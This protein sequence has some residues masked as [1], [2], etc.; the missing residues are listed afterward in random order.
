MHAV[1]WTMLTE[2]LVAVLGHAN[3]CHGRNCTPTFPQ[4]LTGPRPLD[5]AP[6]LGYT[7]GMK[8]AISLPDEVFE[9]AEQLASRLKVSRSELYAR[10]LQEYVCRH[11]PDAVTDAYDQICSELEPGADAFARRAAQATFKRVEW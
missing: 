3:P 11:A 10:A 4:N 2:G 7:I 6:S 8:T 5:N 9:N 1:S